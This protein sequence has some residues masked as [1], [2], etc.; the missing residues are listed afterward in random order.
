M[1]S[2]AGLAIVS[3]LVFVFVFVFAAAA[4]AAGCGDHGRDAVVQN[5][6]ARGI[7]VERAGIQ[8]HLE[9]RRALEVHEFR[10]LGQARARGHERGDLRRALG[11]EVGRRRRR[12]AVGRNGC[13]RIGLPQLTVGLRQAIVRLLDHG[14]VF[15][16]A[17]VEERLNDG[18][19]AWRRRRRG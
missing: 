6:T 9:G 15:G 1:T 14:L 16:G 11:A 13:G 12:G 19:G 5:L 4:S 7:D 8:D 17:L 2:L 10:H 18:I 3:L